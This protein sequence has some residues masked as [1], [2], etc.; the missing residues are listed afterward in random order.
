MD[1]FGLSQLGAF[2]YGPLV[3]LIVDRQSRASNREY[4][5]PTQETQKTHQ[6]FMMGIEDTTKAVEFII[7]CNKDKIFK[8]ND[9]ILI[10][11]CSTVLFSLLTLIPSLTAQVT[12][13]NVTF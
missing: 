9:A 12:Q 11:A 10:T 7:K 6:K 5:S 13:F 2:I 8:L 3:G 4:V 1:I